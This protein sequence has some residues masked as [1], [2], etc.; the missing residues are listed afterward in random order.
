MHDNYDFF[1]NEEDS[2]EEWLKKRPKCD[3][4]DEHIQDDYLYV[5]DDQYI[6]DECMKSNF[7]KWTDD[8]ME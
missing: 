3:F 2:K 6:C 8:Y 5:I 4:C 1:R 7:R